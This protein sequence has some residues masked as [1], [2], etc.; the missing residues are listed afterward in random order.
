MRGWD[1]SDLDPTDFYRRRPTSKSTARKSAFGCLH[2]RSSH[3]R[4]GTGIAANGYI[5][6][7]NWLPVE[8]ESI[9]HAMWEVACGKE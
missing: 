6:T 4:M 7:G 8:P 9:N 1:P 5:D 3:A 2:S